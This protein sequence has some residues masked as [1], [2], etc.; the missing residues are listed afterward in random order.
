MSISGLGRSA[1]EGNDNPLQYSCLENSID[2][3]AWHELQKNETTEQLTHTHMGAFWVFCSALFH[4]V[5][6]L[7]PIPHCLMTV[8]LYKDI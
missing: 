2:R 3:E 7:V 1:G 5:S 4:Y 6:L 8:A